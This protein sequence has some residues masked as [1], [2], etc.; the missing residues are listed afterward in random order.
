MNGPDRPAIYYY[1][2]KWNIAPWIIAHFPE[3]DNYVEPCGG[4]ASVLLQKPRS[5]LETYNDIDGR[6]V[7]FFRVLRDR[8]GEL[9]RAIRLTPYAREEF[10]L[11]RISDGDDLER[12]R[13][14]FISSSMSI[15]T[16]AHKAA[17]GWR[18][19][20]HHG[21]GYTLV[22]DSHF[23]RIEG[24]TLE[25]VARRFMRVQIEHRD[26]QYI[27]ERYCNEASLVYFDPPYVAN[28]RTARKVYVQEWSDKQHS[29]A[30]AMLREVPGFVVVSGYNC[31]LYA[32]LYQGWRRI[33]RM[34][35]TNTSMKRR[36]SLWLSPRTCEALQMPTQRRLF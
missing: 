4:G 29:E 11:C 14:F 28:T 30:A 25:K 7:N 8:P 16:M 24:D 18:S 6:V 15:S 19:N 5:R 34:A 22:S 20:S 33:D 23:D 31:A 2:G 9:I 10:E 32:Q 12:A 27:I 35:R 17:T 36:E 3:H 13:R 1:G 26:Y 21:E